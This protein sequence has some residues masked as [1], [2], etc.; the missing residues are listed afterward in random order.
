MPWKD[1]TKVVNLKHN[2]FDVYIGRPTIFGNPFKGKDRDSVC[3][4]Y[5]EYFHERIKNDPFF[6][7]KVLRLVGKVLGC[8]CKPKRCHGDIIVT[9]LEE[10]SGRT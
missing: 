6:K 9:Y 7:E 5:E 1:K 8:Y 2:F 10:H 4:K 3:D